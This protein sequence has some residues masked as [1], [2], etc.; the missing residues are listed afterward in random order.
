MYCGDHEHYRFLNEAFGRFAHALAIDLG[1]SGLKVGLVSPA[2][3]V[4]WTTGADLATALV[5]GGGAEQDAGE[6]WRLIR[7]ACQAAL[8]SGV[9]ARDAVVAVSVTGQWASS[10]PVAGDGTPVGP[11]V[12]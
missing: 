2:G 9:V 8:A 11:C 4:I 6:W 10:V 3:S 7:D 1:T 12:L 5:P